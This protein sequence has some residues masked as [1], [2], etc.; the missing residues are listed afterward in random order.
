MY[1]A[2]WVQWKGACFCKLGMWLWQKGWK[3]NRAKDD[4]RKLCIKENSSEILQDNE[5][6]KDKMLEANPHL[7][8]C[9]FTKVYKRC[10]F[11]ILNYIVRRRQHCSNYSDCSWYVFLNKENILILK[12]SNILN[13]SVLNECFTLFIFLS[14]YNWFLMFLTKKM[15]KVIEKL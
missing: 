14:L 8:V 13:Y 4:G 7:G 6:T 12:V 10:S 1:V 9:Q 11:G 3:H 15:L 2:G 5:N